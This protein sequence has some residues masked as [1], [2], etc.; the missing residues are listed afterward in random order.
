V[1]TPHLREAQNGVTLPQPIQNRYRCTC[2]NQNDEKV[3]GIAIY[4]L[5][6]ILGALL[7]FLVQPLIAKIILPWFGGSSAVWSAALL[8]FQVCVFAGYAYTH[9]LTT[10]LRPRLQAIVHAALLL[11]SCAF[12][13]IL[14][15]LEWRAVGLGPALQILLLLTATVG[16]PCLL[17][18]ATSPLMQVWSMRRTGSEPPYWLYSLSNAGSLIALLGFPVLLEPSFDANSLAMGWSVAFA[19]FAAMSL[20]TA[21]L[22]RREGTATPSGDPSAHAPSAP[23]MLLWLAFSACACGLLV[24]VTAHL[25]T[26]VAPIPLLWVVP[27]ALYLL[28]FILNFGSRRF[29]DRAT[30]FPWLAAALG[31]MTYLY[32]KSEDNLH[33][34]Y[35]IPAHLIALFV[36]CMACHGELISRKPAPRYLTRFY[37]LIALGGALGGAF[38][39]L[40]APAVFDSYWEFPILLIAIAELSVLVQWRRRGSTGRRWLVRGAMVTGV[41]VLAFLLLRTE[42]TFRRGYV[43][44]ERNFYGV[45]RVRDD[46]P[47]EELE[48]RS[49]VHGTISHGYQFDR[50]R[51]MA[52]SYYSTNSGV[53]RA[54][55]ASQAFGPLRVG[56]VGLGAGVLVSYARQGDIY[57]VY[58]INPA[59]LRMAS[60]EFDF[61]PR[62]R[63]RGAIVSV[64]LGDARLSMENQPPQHFDLLA[65]DA[66]SSD[67]IP[68]HLLTREAMALYLKHLT[69]DGV[70]A[71]HVSNRYL[72]LVP[73]VQRA[74][75]HLGVPAVVIEEPSDEMAHASTWMLITSN[76]DLL[77]AEP[78]RGAELKA[79]SA[80]PDFRGWTDQYSNVW[81][82]LKFWGGE[83]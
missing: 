26:N 50:Y 62:A 75:E 27:L 70:L 35:A 81:S 23:Q 77:R 34:R 67:A 17:L 60:N 40:V 51:D 49:L 64:E 41:C 28:T 53:G 61:L 31:V 72:D 55:L 19:V 80:P 79:A 39:A 66:F 36:I 12:L 32:M 47:G 76:V 13:P 71:V 29:Y 37:L 45:L 73:V 25:S 44:V 83:E 57:T 24:A 38:V 8:F 22:S 78:F 58:E 7:L 14:P 82:V 3:R 30:F 65:I 68:T 46:Y 5:V 18:S 20:G 74:A 9:L 6:V 21:W 1:R 42:V 2:N 56:V 43:S 69:P 15:S 33:L 11:A 52:G 16:L 54:L 59:V 63:E 10:Y 4:A 48:R